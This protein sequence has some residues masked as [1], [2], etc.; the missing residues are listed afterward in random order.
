MLDSDASGDGRRSEP[1]SNFN[2]M[3]IRI[4]GLKKK[5]AIGL[6]EEPFRDDL[7][8]KRVFLFLLGPGHSVVLCDAYKASKGASD[9]HA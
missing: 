7:K 6:V 8:G 9:E 2:R 5:N 4:V 1:T 3:G